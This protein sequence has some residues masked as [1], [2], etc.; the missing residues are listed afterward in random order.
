[1]CY[2]ACN[3]SNA[4]NYSSGCQVSS[5]NTGWTLGLDPTHN[6][7]K[8]VAKINVYARTA[9]QHL[10]RSV[11]VMGPKSVLAVTLGSTSLQTRA[12]VLVRY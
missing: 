10:A 5:C 11:R 7:T 6:T 9:S 4:K 12:H 3:V 8:C 2:V 1:M